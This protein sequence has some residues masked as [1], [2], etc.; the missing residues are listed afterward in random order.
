MQ[1]QINWNKHNSN[2][3]NERF[4]ELAALPDGV[5]DSLQI[6]ET[7]WSVEKRGSIIELITSARITSIRSIPCTKSG[8]MSC[9][10]LTDPLRI[11]A[12]YAEMLMLSL[13]WQPQPESVYIIGFGGG[14]IPMVLHHFFPDL[15]VQS[16]EIEQTAVQ[17]AFTYFGISVDERMKVILD[18]GLA[19]LARCTEKCGFDIIMIDCFS[20]EGIQPGHFST[21]QFYQLCRRKLR[22]SGVVTTHLRWDDPLLS[23]KTAT[24]ARCF[25]FASH[26]S[27]AH[28]IVLFGSDHQSDQRTIIE[29]AGKLA[30]LFGSSI[31]IFSNLPTIISLS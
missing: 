30:S 6:G 15:R 22:D 18:D 14:R 20:P 24:F 3:V 5:L 17:M 16:T 21:S 25:P 27:R 7:Q 12:T 28:S 31:P 29:R 13:L 1:P 26:V 8:V 4:R 23:T 2:T 19:Y 11:D 10:D 9:V